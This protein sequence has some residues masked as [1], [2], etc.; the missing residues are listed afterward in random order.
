LSKITEIYDAIEATL[1]SALPAYTKLPNAYSI[2]DNADIFLN[3]SYA[4]GIGGGSNTNRLIPSRVSISRS[5]E[6]AFI[7]QLN[8]T[9]HNSLAIE[10]QEKALFEDAFLFLKQIELDTTLSGVAVRSQ[11]E[12]D[13]G[14][15]F[16]D[17]EKQRYF[18]LTLA[19][20]V[21][22]IETLV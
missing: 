18:M 22:Y 9:D 15:E 21:E 10:A 11:F 3:K 19:V 7:N 17:G 4:I 14:L 8:A 5:F 20:S 16:L 6:I 13:E 2:E 12:S 1:A